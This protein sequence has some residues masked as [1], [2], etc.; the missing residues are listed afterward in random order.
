MGATSAADITYDPAE[1]VV[2]LPLVID[3]ALL[4]ADR[5]AME[6]DGVDGGRPDRSMDVAAGGGER[7]YR[8]SRGTAYRSDSGSELQ[9]R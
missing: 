5:H 3:D 9:A 6:T 2:V 8:H 4:V 7:R 1:I